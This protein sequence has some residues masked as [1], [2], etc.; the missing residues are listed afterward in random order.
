[1]ESICK[2]QVVVGNMENTRNEGKIIVGKS[3]EVE[4]S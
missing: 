2:A 4:E 3:R 1:M